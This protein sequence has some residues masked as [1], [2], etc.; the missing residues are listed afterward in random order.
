[1]NFVFMK[2]ARSVAWRPKS[3]LCTEH[4]MLKAEAVQVFF[5]LLVTL[6]KHG[7]LLFEGYSIFNRI[8][9]NHFKTN[10]S[11]S[12]K[13]VCMTNIMM[14]HINQIPLRK[15]DILNIMATYG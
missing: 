11:E 8:T 12:G 4:S 7:Q 3:P 2:D 6:F 15:M 5:I 1:M 9:Q 14:L 13:M 10:W